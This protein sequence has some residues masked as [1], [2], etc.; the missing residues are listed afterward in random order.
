[1]ARLRDPKSG[2]S[3]A[4]IPGGISNHQASPD[5]A[6]LGT[7]FYEPLWLFSRGKHL[8]SFEQLRNR[9]ISIGPEGSASHVLAIEFLGVLAC[10]RRNPQHCFRSHRRKHLWN[11][12][13]GALTQRF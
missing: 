8:D 10:S 2:A 13:M 7:L 1:M 4:I 11:Y 12:L 3:I 9:R 5:L 6:S